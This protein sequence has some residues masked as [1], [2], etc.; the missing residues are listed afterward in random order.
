MTVDL[1]CISNAPYFIS[2][3][4][5]FLQNSE[6]KE[7]LIQIFLLLWYLKIRKIWLK[8]NKFHFLP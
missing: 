2:V 7:R 4:L 3:S 5:H 1:D 6:I 8:N